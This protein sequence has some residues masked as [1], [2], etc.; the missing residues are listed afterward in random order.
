VVCKSGWSKE[1]LIA[2]LAIV[3]HDAEVAVGDVKISRLLCRKR[4]EC[5]CEIFDDFAL[6]NAPSCCD[7]SFVCGDRVAICAG[8]FPRAI[9]LVHKN[10]FAQ[11]C[12]EMFLLRLCLQR[13]LIALQ[14]W[15]REQRLLSR[16]R[17]LANNDLLEQ[18]LGDLFLLDTAYGDVFWSVFADLELVEGLEV[19]S[20]REATTR[21]AQLTLSTMTSEQTSS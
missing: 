5:T 9:G 17:I 11:M 19:M 20:M 8:D 1:H 6:A 3:D 18:N 14:A 21:L 4:D 10:V 15:Q 7:G 2:L 13:L 12:N 16:R